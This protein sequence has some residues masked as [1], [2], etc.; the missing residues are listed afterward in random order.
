MDAKE[1]VDRA[2]EAGAEPIIN[3]ANGRPGIY[4]QLGP[5]VGDLPDGS[6]IDGQEIV[7]ELQPRGHVVLT[8]VLKIYEREKEI[9]EKLKQLGDAT[10]EIEAEL[11]NLDKAKEDTR[12]KSI[13]DV[14]LKVAEI[15]SCA[16]D[17]E[18]ADARL[19]RS[20]RLDLEHL[21]EKRP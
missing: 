1:W 21:L 13:E 4:M 14:L 20:I 9:E 15:E 6:G 10:P 3:H 7:A 19:A 17:G 12:A 16:G 18:D 8:P 11:E 2:I 5:D